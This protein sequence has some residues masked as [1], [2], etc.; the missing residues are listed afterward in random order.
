M[1]FDLDIKTDRLPPKTVCLTY[2]DG[3]GETHGPGGQLLADSTRPCEA[4]TFVLHRRAG[5]R[6]IG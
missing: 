5:N 6:N 4:E 2:D 1:F 3:P